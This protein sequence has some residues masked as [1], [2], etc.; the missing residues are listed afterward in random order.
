M[1][2][3][4]GLVLCTIHDVYPFFL[5]N[6]TLLHDRTNERV[7]TSPFLYIDKQLLS[8]SLSLMDCVCVCVCVYLPGHGL[9][10]TSHYSMIVPPRPWIGRTSHYSMIVPPRP[11]IGRNITLH[12]VPPKPQGSLQAAS[13]DKHTQHATP[14][15]FYDIY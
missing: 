12:I 2:D 4:N 11:W 15:N 1:I 3:Y 14:H 8:L 13:S 6:I 9:V 7:G 10:G 5:L